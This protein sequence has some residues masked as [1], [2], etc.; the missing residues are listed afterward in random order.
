MRKDNTSVHSANWIIQD[1]FFL[2]LKLKIGQAVG[3]FS[4]MTPLVRSQINAEH[5]WSIWFTHSP[6]LCCSSAWHLLQCGLSLYKGWSSDT[7]KKQQW[8]YP[9]ILKIRLM[10]FYS[11]WLNTSDRKEHVEYRQTYLN[12]Q[13]NLASVVQTFVVGVKALFPLCQSKHAVHQLS[14]V[15]FQG[16]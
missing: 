12:P 2:S 15:W 7:V 11:L 5:V 4:V 3:Y 9:F 16:N 14:A 10:L 1:R 6:V 13:W 8:C